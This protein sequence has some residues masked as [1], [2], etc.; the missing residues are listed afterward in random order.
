[1][2]RWHPDF[3]LKGLP[4]IDIAELPVSPDDDYKKVLAS[5]IEMRQYAERTP[6]QRVRRALFS[7]LSS[8][9]EST[10]ITLPS[11]SKQSLSMDGIPSTLIEKV[12]AP[13]SLSILLTWQP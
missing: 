13:T 4:E 5:P 9:S 7:T 3:D 8:D 12:S 10:M 6:S 1:L 2:A 11:P